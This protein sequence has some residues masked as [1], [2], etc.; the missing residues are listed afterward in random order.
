VIGPVVKE[1]PIEKDVVEDVG[2]VVAVAEVDVP[3]ATVYV[4]V[5]GTLTVDEDIREMSVTVVKEGLKPSDVDE[6]IIADVEVKL[7]VT[8]GVICSALVTLVTDTSVDTGVVDLGS[9]GPGVERELMEEIPV[10]ND[11][12]EDTGAVVGVAEVDVLLATVD[13]LIGGTLSVDED[14]AEMSVTVTVVV[15]VVVV[16]AEGLKPSDAD[17][18][19][20]A[21]VEV[22]L[23]VTDGV[24]CS[25]VV[26]LVTGTSV[27]TGFVDPGIG[28]PGVEREIVEE[29]PVG[30]DVVED[31][32]EVLVVSEV[33]V[34]LA[35]ADVII[36]STP[37]DEVVAEMSVNVTVVVVVVVAA[38]GLKPCD[39]DEDI[40]ADVEV[41][42]AVT[43][44]V[45]CS[46]VVTLVTDTSVDTGIVNPGSERPGVEREILDEM[47]VG[48]DVVEDIGAVLLVAEV[49]VLFA[50][51]EVLVGGTPAADEDVADMSLN[52]T[53]VVA[54]EGLKSS[55]AD[56]ATVDAE[57]KLAVT[58]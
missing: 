18:A 14:V 11:V 32:G 12:V 29:I 47:P 6:V 56:E 57:V 50:T 3:L 37:A 38:E 58:E 41:K 31:I 2:V 21:D 10:G 55:D 54:A 51:V 7:A 43:E 4:L 25:A 34:L 46:A 9:G 19:T 13:V 42:L 36:G 8:E 20:V 24:V 44:G 28:G 15:V 5:D 30:D 16:A 53:V 40:V 45:I 39:A 35:T 1:L 17:E 26:I 49:D 52:V 33:D 27:D 48:G 22:K 23:A